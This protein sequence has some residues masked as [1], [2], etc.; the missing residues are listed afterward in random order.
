MLQER[1]H[2]QHDIHL[3][4]REHDSNTNVILFLNENDLSVSFLNRWGVRSQCCD[5]LTHPCSIATTDLSLATL[6]K[7]AVF[8]PFFLTRKAFIKM[9]NTNDLLL[10]I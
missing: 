7:T 9:R 6:L 5:H 8:V 4:D 10:I 2:H 3:I 1:C